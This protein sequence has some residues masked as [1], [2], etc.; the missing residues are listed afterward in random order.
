M[1]F[2]LRL[3]RKRD[4]S[5][6][7]LKNIKFECWK[8]IWQNC[9]TKNNNQYIGWCQP[10]FPHTKGQKLN[11]HMAIL[12]FLT[13]CNWLLYITFIQKHSR[14][15]LCL[16]DTSQTR[17]RHYVWM[18]HHHRHEISVFGFV[19]RMYLLNLTYYTAKQCW[20]LFSLLFGELILHWTY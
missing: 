15:F 19:H 4:D 10:R 3:W 20:L 13:F 8:H 1:G 11:T 12:Y 17:T 14:V 9:I 7:S 6:S 5:A 16:W 18:S 2:F